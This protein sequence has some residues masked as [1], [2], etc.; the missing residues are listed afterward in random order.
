[1]YGYMVVCMVMYV[2]LLVVGCGGIM[3]IIIIG[4]IG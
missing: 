1:M 2:W 4:Y 3:F